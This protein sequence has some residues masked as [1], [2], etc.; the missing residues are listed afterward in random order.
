MSSIVLLESLTSMPELLS[1]WR[2]AN[3]GRRLDRAENLTPAFSAPRVFFISSDV[4][5]GNS[6]Q[7]SLFRPG[8]A[9]HEMSEGNWRTR[10]VRIPG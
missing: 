4:F 8:L 2:A 9:M 10:S 1:H 5:A 3:H 7:A 6:A